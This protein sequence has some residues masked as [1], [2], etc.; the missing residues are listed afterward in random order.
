VN[1]SAFQF[2]RWETP[3]ENDPVEIVDVDYVTSQAILACR[4]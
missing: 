4:V 1:D 3:F 2:G